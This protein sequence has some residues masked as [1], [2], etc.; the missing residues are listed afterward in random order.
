MKEELISS[1]CAI[2]IFFLS[3]IIGVIF[4]I[5][6]L[7]WAFVTAASITTFV[8]ILFVMFILLEVEDAQKK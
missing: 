2:L 7:D 1:M 4:W 3:F 6:T 5:N 8:T